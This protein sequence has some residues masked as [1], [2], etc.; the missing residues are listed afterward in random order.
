MNYNKVPMI[1]PP[2]GK[3]LLTRMISIGF[4]HYIARISFSSLLAFAQYQGRRAEC[5]RANR[6]FAIIGED[7]WSAG[8]I[9]NV[10]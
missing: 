7:Y 5:S 9:W 10:R 4:W 2:N 1:F 8:L 3:R 6:R